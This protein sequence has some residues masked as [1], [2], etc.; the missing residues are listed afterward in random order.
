MY[1]AFVTHRVKNFT[2]WCVFCAKWHR[3]VILGDL[4]IRIPKW[5]THWKFSDIFNTNTVYFYSDHCICQ[6]AQTPDA[7]FHDTIFLKVLRIVSCYNYHFMCHF[8][9]HCFSVP[10]IWPFSCHFFLHYSISL[11]NTF[12]T[13]L[14]FSAS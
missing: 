3:V 7:R 4:K 2:S 1:F 10:F 5:C 6:T 13:F 12:V 14:P 8:L 9:P 11:V